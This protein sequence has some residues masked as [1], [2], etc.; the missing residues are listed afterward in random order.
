M[1]LGDVLGG[2]YRVERVIGQG[3]MGIVFA[4]RHI[5]L[6]QRVAVKVLLP[7]ATDSRDQV[8]RFMREARSAVRLK[9]EHAVHVT[10]V[11]RLRSGVP[12]MVMELLDGSDLS[13]VVEH[14]PLPVATAVDF[15][16]Q[17]CEAIAEAHALGMVHR[18]IKPS[19]L[20]VVRG[21]HG[22]SVVKVLDFGLAKHRAVTADALTKSA[23]VMGSPPYMSPEQLKSLRDVDA[24]TDIWS[25]GVTLYELLTRALPFEAP[26][27]PEVCARVLMGAATPP[28]PSLV[29]EQ[30]WRVIERCL[31]KDPSQRFQTV[32][33]LATALQHFAAPAG[34][35]SAERVANLLRATANASSHPPPADTGSASACA[36]TVT[37]AS[38]DARAH[39]RRPGRV[40]ILLGAGVL[41]AVALSVVVGLAARRSTFARSFEPSAASA[42]AGSSAITIATD[43]VVAS[44]AALPSSVSSE[45]PVTIDLDTARDAG[46]TT[47]PR[48]PSSLPRS[49]AP[50]RP[51][52]SQPEPTK[53]PS[54]RF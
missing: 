48:A 1:K 28:D 39:D 45:A 19:N 27:V 17:A 37:A 38:F 30:L 11:G 40:A 21:V 10:D 32:W 23:V 33:E 44:A 25:L 43:A 6:H 47:P 34:L 29:P 12:F 16:L 9:S 20:Y 41:A 35:G 36:D 15:V 5:E 53:N 2:K 52:T 42:L 4:A 50:P 31:A 24:R 13:R 49:G 14:A 22:V 54:A 46:A 51:K 26:T 7:D 8:E 18:D 3:G